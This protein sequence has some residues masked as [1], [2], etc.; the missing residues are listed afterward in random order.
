MLIT[1]RLCRHQP[2][3]PGEICCPRCLPTWLALRRIKQDS[4]ATTNRRR[5]ERLDEKTRPIWGYAWA[6]RVTN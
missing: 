5:I 2:A 3:A 6:A 4:R 1:C